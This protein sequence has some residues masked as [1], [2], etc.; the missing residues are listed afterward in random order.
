MLSKP[1]STLEYIH[2]RNIKYLTDTLHHLVKGRLWLQVLIAMVLGIAFGLIINPQAG[3][4]TQ[5]AA[6]VIG[7]WVAL[8]GKLFLA[9]IQMIVVPLIL[10]SIIRGICAANDAAQL[11]STGAWL[12][13]YFFI[14]TI[15]AVIIGISLGLVIKPGEYIKA[16]APVIQEQ[17]TQSHEIQDMAQNAIT[18]AAQTRPEDIHLADVPN[19]ITQV[20]PTNPLGAMVEGDMLQIVIFAVILG[21]GLMSVEPKSSKPLLELFGSI[22]QVSMAIVAQVMR[23]APLAVFGLLAQAM[24]KTGPDVL[25]GLG[26]YAGTVVL[27]MAILLAVYTFLAAVLGKQSPL[28]FLSGIREPF[29]LGFSTNSSAATMPITVRAAE[30]RLN[31]R[32]SISQ[33]VIPLG[34]TINMGGTALYQ[35]LAT[36][37]MAQMFSIDLPLSALIALVATALGASIGTPAVPGVGIIVLSSILSSV[38]VPLSGLALII[39]LDRILERFRTSLNVTGDLVACAIM[40]RIVPQVKSADEEAREEAQHEKRREKHN[41]DVVLSH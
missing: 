14:T 13:V 12:A 26:I 40:D 9:F 25:A 30:E 2:P 41:E 37:F 39:G 38:G 20:L 3:Y 16:D 27:G 23:I 33:F 8:P 35:G 6:L 32:P 19:R 10:A 34:A 22:Q 5:K 24:I 29:L 15:M 1:A 4:V 21:I 18:S 17:S 11:K 31:I 36:I 7:E 28:K